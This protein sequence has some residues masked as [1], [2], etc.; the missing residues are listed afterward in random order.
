[1]VSYLSLCLAFGFQLRLL[2]LILGIL[3]F[4]N[5][6]LSEIYCQESYEPSSID[7]QKP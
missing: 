4:K 2:R 7:T 5:I 1:M 3:F 6:D